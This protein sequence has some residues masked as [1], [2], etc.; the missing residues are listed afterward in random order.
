MLFRLGPYITFCGSF[1]AFI[2]LPFADGV[3]GHAT[4]NIGVFFMLAVLSTEVFGVI[5]AGYGS[6]SKWSLFGG[7]REA[8]QVVSYEVPH[9]HVRA[10]AGHRRRLDGPDR[11]S[12]SMQAG[13]FWNWFVFHD[14]F[15]FVA[16]WVYFTCATA[17]CKRAPFDLAEAESELVAGFHTEYCGLRWS[18][19]FMAEY[20]CM[21]AV[22]GLAAL[23]FLGGW[24]TGFLPF[25]PGRPARRRRRQRCINVD[26]LHPKGWV[27]V[28]VMMWVR[29]TL[30]GCASIR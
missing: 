21:F 16:F 19:F 7:M 8:A 26:R 4:L 27:L 23:L 24:N 2:A 18:F 14:P 15:T 28:F 25:E 1:L 5:L 11:P 22:S 12:A 10:G 13:L 29:W 30:P 20:G 9:G 3:V 6:G 17:S